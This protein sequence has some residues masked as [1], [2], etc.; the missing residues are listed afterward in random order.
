[1]LAGRTAEQLE[2]AG[3]ILSPAVRDM[4]G[5]LDRENEVLSELAVYQASRIRYMEARSMS[6]RRSRREAPPTPR[7][8]LPAIRSAPN[9]PGR[10]AGTPAAL[11]RD[12]Q[13]VIACSCR[14]SMWVWSRSTDTRNFSTE[15]TPLAE[16]PMMGTPTLHATISVPRV[17]ALV[18]ELR[19]FTLVCLQRRSRWRYF[20]PRS[21]PAT[22]VPP[23]NL[24]HGVY[25]PH[26]S[27]PA[28]SSAPPGDLLYVRRARGRAAVPPLP[29][30]GAEQAVAGRAVAWEP[31][32][33]QAERALLKP[34]PRRKCCF[35]SSSGAA[36]Q[37]GTG[38]CWRRFL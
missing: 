2:A 4:I 7:I 5:L 19:S 12:T 28:R 10:G 17:R 9:A 20:R 24:L 6:L 14:R 34:I 3:E 27:E 38:V 1:M 30:S 16:V 29:L 13:A 32:S 18:T 33:N 15:G 35:G 25:E 31:T 37:P 11:R 23:D 21:P 22:S 26:P 36:G 8:R